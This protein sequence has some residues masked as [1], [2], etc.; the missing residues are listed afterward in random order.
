MKGVRSLPSAEQYGSLD[1]LSRR[2]RGEKRHFDVV[3]AAYAVAEL[4]SPEAQAAAVRRLWSH[5][6]DLLILVEAGTPRGWAAVQAARMQVIRQEQRRL[7]KGVQ[8]QS[9]TALAPGAHT[10]APCPHDGQ[11]PM[12][13]TAMWCHFG[14]RVR[15][16]GIHRQ[17]KRAA[18]GPALR[19]EEAEKFAFVV[20]RR[21][22][23]PEYAPRV[24]FL[25]LSHDNTAFFCSQRSD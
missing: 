10:V 8:A 9:S 7:R 23:R 5:A 24:H 20:L 25:S 4:E 2:L 14:Q 6:R 13:G 21:G 22:P 18:G 1:A 11:C 15:R 17:A 19:P 12:A 3:V 16:S